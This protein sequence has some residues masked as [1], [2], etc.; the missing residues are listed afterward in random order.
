MSLTK[1]IRWARQDNTGCV[2]DDGAM[3]LLRL[4]AGG[5]AMIGLAVPAHADPK[6]DAAFLSALTKA[7]I[8]YN[9]GIQA[10][11]AGKTACELM[12]E[13][14]P[15]IDVVNKV[16][17]LNPGFTISGAAKFTAIAASAYCPQ[18]LNR[19]GSGGGSD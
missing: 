10:V 12:D 7:G 3:R 16:V 8:T 2:G 17:E 6:V 9:S 14:Q 1:T 4:L 5:A 18:H 11:E 13:G 15:E 19:V